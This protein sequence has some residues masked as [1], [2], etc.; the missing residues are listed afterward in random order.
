MIEAIGVLDHG[1]ARLVSYMQ[2]ATFVLKAEQLRTFEEDPELHAD[3]MLK[4]LL[5]MKYDWSGD[6]EVVRNARVSYDADWRTGE[7]EDKDEKLLGYMTKNRHTS[8][9]ESME[10]NFEIKCPIF[11]ARQWH[12]HRTWSYNEVS[13]RYTELP[14]EYYIPDSRSVGT[15]SSSNKQMRT[16]EVNAGLNEDS[17]RFCE[18]L[19]LHSA[20]G[21]ALY[22]HYIEKGIPRELARCFLGLNT[23]TRYFAKVDLHNLMHFLILR[24]HSHAQYEISVYALALYDLIAEVVPVVHRKFM[25]SLP[26]DCQD[27]VAALRA[28]S[29]ALR[30]K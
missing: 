29:S 12:R 19:Q 4:H 8:P 9:F 23:Y 15:Q 3:E 21:F 5:A 30:T 20:R 6:L 14:E 25:S 10:F 26:A 22:H 1:H 2:P 13:A 28:K 16:F 24:F 18:D 7:D 27:A 17:V 11:V